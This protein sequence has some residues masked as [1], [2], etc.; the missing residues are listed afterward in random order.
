MRTRKSKTVWMSRDSGEHSG[1][2]YFWESKPTNGAGE[3][4]SPK[5]DRVS[6]QE[7]DHLEVNCVEFL[8]LCKDFDIP[9]PNPGELLKI[10]VSVQSVETLSTRKDLVRRLR[11]AKKFDKALLAEAVSWVESIGLNDADESDKNEW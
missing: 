7:I 11:G 4:E 1:Y 6:I 9:V 3:F 8:R 5:V 10:T 2:V